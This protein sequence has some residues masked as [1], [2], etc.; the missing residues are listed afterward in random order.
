MSTPSH[1]QNLQYAQVDVGQVDDVFQV[2]ADTAGITV[3]GVCPRCDGGTSTTFPL[4]IAG[5]K[6]LF[7]WSKGKV[8][9]L[10]EQVALK[11]TETFFCECGFAHSGQ[12]ENTLF[13]GC[14]AQWKF[15]P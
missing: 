8:P 4:G 11:A 2:T 15:K 12:P 10:A 6:G 14:G 9:S 3:T 13:E 1:Q 7:P 5:T